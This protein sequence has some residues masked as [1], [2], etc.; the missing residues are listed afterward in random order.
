M[1]R[2]KRNKFPAP[3]VVRC[4]S[5]CIVA[6]GATDFLAFTLAQAF[7][8]QQ[9]RVGNS[10]GSARSDE[11]AFSQMLVRFELEDGKKGARCQRSN[12]L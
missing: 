2:L 10:S 5:A 1:I 12:L 11:L 9:L 6:F 4:T 3:D 7:C 8:C